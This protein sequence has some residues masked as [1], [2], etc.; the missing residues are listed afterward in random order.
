MITSKHYLRPTW[1]EINLDN[2]KYNVKELKRI[3]NKKTR[4]CAVVKADAYGHGAIIVAK[5]LID[6]GVDFLSVATLSE[7]IE[8]RNAGYEVPIIILGYTPDEQGDL[9]IDYNIIQTIYSIEQANNLS[10]LAKRKNKEI[11]V[12]IKIDTGMSRLGFQTSEKDMENIKSI[13]LMDNLKIQ[14]MYTHFAL[15]DEKEKKVTYEQ[16]AKFMEFT[17]ELEKSGYSVP[18]KH[19]SNSAA[20]IDL[21]EM[22]LDMVRAGIMLYGLYPSQE[23]DKQRIKLKPVMAL[24]TKVAHVKILTGNQGVSYGHRYTTKKTMQIA[25]LPVGYA[26]GLSRLLTNKISVNYKG[27]NLPMIGTICMDQCMI[28]ASS[29]NI[30]VGEEVAIFSNGSNNGATVEDLAEHL[31]TINYEIVCM[32]GSRVP[33]VYMEDNNVVHIRDVLLK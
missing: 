17:K 24:K 33:R 11:V 26:D 20:I 10:K 9:L 7:G 2:L 31:G 8:L 27:K 3:I 13:F 5:T 22:N 14:G 30:K 4:I 15:A 16:F 19:V 23:V 25:T 12:H 21:P 28:D 1:A 18:I 6:S 32:I 29:V